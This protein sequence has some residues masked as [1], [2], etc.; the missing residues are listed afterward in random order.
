MSTLEELYK[1]FIRD[2]INEKYQISYSERLILGENLL[3]GYYFLTFTEEDAIL[4]QIYNKILVENCKNPSIVEINKFKGKTNVY[5]RFNKNA[6]KTHLE[7]KT[8]NT[9]INNGLFQNLESGKSI[10]DNIT[11]MHRLSSCIYS[12]IS[13]LEIHHGNKRKC[14]NQISNLTPIEKSLHDEIDMLDE[15][16]FSI[17]T[18]E[19]HNEFKKSLKVQKRNTLSSRDEIILAILLDFDNAL[20]PSE[21]ASKWKNKIGL[22]K[23]YEIKNHYFYLKDF[24]KFLYSLM[25]KEKWTLNEN[26]DC[27]WEYIKEFEEHYTLC[28]S[29]AERFYNNKLSYAKEIFKKHLLARPDGYY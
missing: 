16:E 1:L 17:R 10:I 25:F 22:T 21:I 6:L 18:K 26:Y 20:T 19:L 28:N 7:P 8:F 24:L 27:Q 3:N 14:S 29:G 9:L 2:K 4:N 5:E 11:T 13:G 12:N 15:P 23:I